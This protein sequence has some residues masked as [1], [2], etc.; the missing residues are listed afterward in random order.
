MNRTAD[1]DFALPA[2]RIAQAPLAARDES[3][4]MVV[5]RA[6]GAIRHRRFRDLVELVRPGDALV[7]NTTRVMRARLLGTR[8]SGA[9]AEVLLLKPLG[10][11]R[12]EAMVSPGQKLRPGRMVRVAP[13]FEVDILEITDRRTR[14]VRLRAQGPVGEAIARHGHVPLPPYITHGDT[15]ED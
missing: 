5:E 6:T 12:W 11:D 4:L 8:A 1:Y 9:P 13:G 7:V 14:V 2:D 3:R 15:V 10:D